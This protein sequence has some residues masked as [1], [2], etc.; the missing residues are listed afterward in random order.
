M[1]KLEGLSHSFASLRVIERIDFTVD[2]SD[3]LGILGP[4]GAGKSTLFNLIA[5]VLQPNAGRILL[6]GRDITR[7][8]RWDRCRAGIGRTYQIPRPFAQ[9]T[10]FENVLVAAA[11]GARLSIPRA[12]REAVEVLERT[13]LSHR[14]RFLAGDLGLL[15]MKQLELAKALAVRPRLLLL[16]EIA[17]GLTDAETETLLATIRAAHAY[18]VTIVWIEHVV[19]ALRRLVSRLAV[20]SGGR[21][22]ADGAPAEVLADPRVKEV[23]LGAA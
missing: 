16:D 21:F 11:H 9:M 3:I 8:P 19:Q 14:S 18:G 22:I 1:L 5:G 13:G 12:R 2:S 23:Y 15:D 10:V 4:N 20:L 7:L 17:G 6:E